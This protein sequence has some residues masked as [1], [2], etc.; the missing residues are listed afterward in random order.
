M[1]R[2]ILESPYGS[3]DDAV[4]AENVRYARACLRDCV[5]RGDSPIA[6]HLLFTQPGVLKDR[7]PEERK[8]GIEAGLAWGPVAEA[9]VV[10]TD[11]GITDGMK[12]GIERAIEEGRP[13]EYRELEGWEE[14]TDGDFDP[15]RNEAPPGLADAVA[16]E[17]VWASGG[18]PSYVYVAAVSSELRPWVVKLR[19]QGLSLWREGRMYFFC[20]MTTGAPV[21]VSKADIGDWKRTVPT[22]DPTQESRRLH[23]AW[24]SVEYVDNRC[25]CRYHPDDDNGTHGG[26]PHVHPCK[27]H[28]RKIACLRTDYAETLRYVSAKIQRSNGKLSADDLDLVL[29]R[30]TTMERRLERG[31]L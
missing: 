18:D 1:R 12:Q 28:R 27:Q 23:L 22:D 3:D 30:I 13:V 19:R 2:V 6:S 14:P 26:G 25:G 31:D 15:E 5:L 9:T 24:N 29:A 20:E 17:G 16:S 7:D 21:K 8:L 11:R 4:V 10:Y